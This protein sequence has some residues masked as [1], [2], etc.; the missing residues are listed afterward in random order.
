MV[1][2]TVVCRLQAGQTRDQVADSFGRARVAILSPTGGPTHEE[3]RAVVP[4]TELS[5]IG[6]FKTKRY[7]AGFAVRAILG[8]LG[9]DLLRLD[10]PG[11]NL[12]Y[13]RKARIAAPWTLPGAWEKKAE[14]QNARL[15]PPEEKAG[16]TVAGAA[17]G[18]S[19]ASQTGGRVSDL[20][21]KLA[22]GKAL[23]ERR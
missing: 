6:P 19:P 10:F 12:P 20:R 23:L 9:N 11:S 1:G 15:E 13:R 16:A 2:T 7:P 14:P 8:G 18:P 3:T 22:A 21:A 17:E 5:S 4:S